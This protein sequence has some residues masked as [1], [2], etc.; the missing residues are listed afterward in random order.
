MKKSTASISLALI[1]TAAFLAGCHSNNDEDR[2]RRAGVYVG[3]RIGTGSGFRG[4][5]GTSVSS[6]ASA[7]GGFGATGG[8][9]V[10]S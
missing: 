9:G 7:R 3:P 6:G 2:Q 4:T 10:G 1:G 5:S 8:V